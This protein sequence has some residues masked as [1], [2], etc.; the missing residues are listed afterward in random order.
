[1]KLK[2]FSEETTFHH[3]NDKKLNGYIYEDVFDDTFFS[4]IKKQVENIFAHSNTQTFLTHNTTFSINDQVKKIVSHKQNDR[5]QHVLFDLF[6][7]KDYFYQTKDTIKD[8]ANNITKNSL[9]PVFFK[10]IDTFYNVEPFN[11]KDWLC[12]RL[13]LNVLAYQEFLS[14]HLDSNHLMY[15][16]K[17][18]TDARVY[19]ITFYLENHIDG[20][21]GELFSINGFT[22][23]PVENS[24]IAINGNQVLHGVTANMHP[25]KK[26]RLAFTMRFAHI[27]DLLL[28]GHPN[29]T[30]YSSL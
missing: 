19:S 9:S 10:C 15:N 24:A 11:N 23:K 16:T 28:P 27:D 21:G 3:W 6:F 2:S 1:M 13:H 18:F 14:L 12:Y 20:A 25:E 8:W 17:D 29:K 5:E 22:H 7:E 26:T 4:T 30:L